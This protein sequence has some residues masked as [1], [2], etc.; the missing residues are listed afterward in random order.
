MSSHR[1]LCASASSASWPIVGATYC[2]H[3]RDDCCAWLLPTRRIRSNLILALQRYGSVH[4]AA[5]PCVLSK[6]CRLYRLT[7]RPSHGAIA[8]T[9]LSAIR[10]LASLTRALTGALYVCPN[11]A[12]KSNSASSLH[13]SDVNQELPLLQPLANCIGTSLL[14]VLTLCPNI[15]YCIQNP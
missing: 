13:C 4:V 1:V 5:A 11:C 9:A 10:F 12:F 8:L 14:S 15:R 2:C 6:G 7:V 3:S